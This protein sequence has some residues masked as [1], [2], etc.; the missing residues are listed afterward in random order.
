MFSIIGNVDLSVVAE[1]SG[2]IEIKLNALAALFF[3]STR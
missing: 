1:Q 3:L 2:R